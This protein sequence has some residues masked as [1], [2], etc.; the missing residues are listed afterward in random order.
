M[1]LPISRLTLISAILC[2]AILRFTNLNWDAG[3]RLHP[4]EALIVNGALSIKFFSALFP[5]FHDYNGLSVYL[6]AA[7]SRLI[8]LLS[9]SAHWSQTP[10]GITVAGRFLSACLSTLSIPLVYVVGKKLL[11]AT[12]GMYAAILMAFTPLAIQLAH[13]YT[14]ESILIFLLLLLISASASYVKQSN[15]LNVFFMAV[16]AGLLLATKNTAYL[17]LPIP[18][19]SIHIAHHPPLSK[20]MHTVMFILTAIFAF[21]A[22][23]PYSFLDGSGYLA[24]SRY[25]ADVVNGALL[26]DWTLQFQETN[27][28][29]WIPA[30]LYAMGLTIIIGTA[31]IIY[32]ML[33]SP[34]KKTMRPLLAIWSTGFMMFLAFTYLKFTRYAGPL[35]PL[36]SLFGGMCL[37]GL[38]RTNTGKIA[39]YAIVAAQIFYGCMFL[40]VYSNPHT[41]LTASQWISANVPQSS[42][43]L[44]EEWNSIIRFSR[45]ELSNKNYRITSFNFYSP[46]TVSKKQKLDMLLQHT[47]YILIQSPKV[48]HTVTRL[49]HRYPDTGAFYKNL[50][51]GGLNFTEVKKFTSYP[52]LGFLAMD[53]ERAEETF[54]V[55]DHPTITLYKRKQ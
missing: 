51:N 9:G 10:E 45:T 54:T 20:W 19:L 55:F 16:L 36:F 49:T 13:F 21:F 17:F 38:S 37:T 25:L 6:L 28:S 3:G 47:D 26:M 23:S 30:L 33:A 40:P 12:A 7:A 39:A 29:F 53:D 1:R 18:L 41:S 52:R 44:T 2:G 35:I 14:T 48:K 46:D 32:T 8:S 43:I 11:N 31:G 15:H 42:A 34:A 24:R 50:E 27:G 22:G 4:D 5:G